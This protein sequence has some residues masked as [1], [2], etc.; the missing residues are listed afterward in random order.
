MGIARTLP[1]K[2]GAPEVNVYECKRCKISYTT[3]DHFAI[4]GA[5]VR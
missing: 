2:I 3:E 1:D 5:G 4:A